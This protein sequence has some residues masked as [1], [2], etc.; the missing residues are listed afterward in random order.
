ML[1]REL[2]ITFP[3]ALTEVPLQNLNGVDYLFGLLPSVSLPLLVVLLPACDKPLCHR[4]VHPL[5]L[6][7]HGSP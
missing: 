3:T 1:L 2:G 5:A 4:N 6:F 7:L